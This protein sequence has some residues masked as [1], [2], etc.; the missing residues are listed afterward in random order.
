MLKPYIKRMTN[1]F[2]L[3]GEL[4]IYRCMHEYVDVYSEVQQV[5]TEDLINSPFGGRYC[6][7]ISPRDRS[8]LYRTVAFSFYSDK[9][10]TIP[11]LFEGYYT[12]KNDCKLINEN[13]HKL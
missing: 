9:N 4:F 6:G 5:D 11:T 10:T 7:L 12:F 1:P 13:Y 8:S 3:C 2:F